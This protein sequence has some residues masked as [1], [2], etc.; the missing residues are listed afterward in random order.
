MRLEISTAM[1]V[2]VVVFLAL[3]P[4]SDVVGYKSFGGSCYLH[5]YPEDGSRIAAQASVK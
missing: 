2:H 4:R 3:T 5:L 1:K